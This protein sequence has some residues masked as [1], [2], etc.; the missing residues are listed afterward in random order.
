MK[1]WARAVLHLVTFTALAASRAAVGD[2]DDAAPKPGAQAPSLNAEQRRAV[3][4]EV[5]H[6]VAA[7]APQR[8]EAL[9]TILD[10]LVLLADDTDV[11]VAAAQGH[12][13]GA[14]LE[15]LLELQKSGA[16]ASLKMIQAAQADEAKARASSTLANAR[17]ARHWGPLAERSAQERGRLVAAVVAGR[18]ALVRA[19]LPG[20]H[21]A[22][23]AVLPSRALL[24]VDGIQVPG[25]VL[26]ALEQPSELQSAGLLLEV[27]NPPPGLAPGA[28]VPLA[29][30]G[31]ERKGF[32]LPS[33]AL[34]YGADGAYVYK[35]LAPKTPQDPV[36]FI[37]VKVTPLL[38]YGGGWLVQ[39]VDD[40][41]DIVVHGA[42]VLWSLE[43]V[44]AHPADDE[45]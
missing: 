31:E 24:D 44:G 39:G 26:G 32:S 14:E 27:P 21:A 40:D 42:G 18:A 8:V 33:E 37:A 30:L 34:L 3:G 23:A 13:A 38:P 45:D 16:G 17:F 10:P 12:A 25:R 2:D 6:P 22:G 5:T 1:H 19:E 36:R 15:R 29:L 11:T 7:V 35:Q 28:R 9:G 43:G 4:L 41:D 20:R